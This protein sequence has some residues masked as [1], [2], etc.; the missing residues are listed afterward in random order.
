M[1]LPSV[2]YG[3]LRRL[4]VSEIALFAIDRAAGPHLADIGSA[5]PLK[6]DFV[7][8]RDAEF[9]LQ[10]EFGNAASVLSG[11]PNEF[12]SA[13]LAATPISKPSSCGSGAAF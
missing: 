2:V 7:G 3:L 10:R 11:T 1:H 13:T 9:V 12:A 4:D 8:Q 6:F 5:L